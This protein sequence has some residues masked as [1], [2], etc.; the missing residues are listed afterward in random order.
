MRLLDLRCELK[1]ARNLPLLDAKARVSALL[2]AVLLAYGALASQPFSP[3]QVRHERPL[4]SASS[5]ATVIQVTPPSTQPSPLAREP[6]PPLSSPRAQLASLPI[7]ASFDFFSAYLTNQTYPDIVEGTP[8]DFGSTNISQLRQP[9]GGISYWDYWVENER[10]D[11][12]NHLWRDDDGHWHTYRSETIRDAA[13]K[14]VTAYVLFDV[15]GPGVMD[16]LWFTHDP[17][18]SF[19]AVLGE[20]NPLSFLEPQ[21][22]TQW[23][24]LAKLGNLRIQVDDQIVFDGP[25]KDWFSGQAQH[26][27]PLLR[28]IAVWKYI[29]FGSD[30][31][32][33]PI[34]YQNRLKVSVYGGSG[35]PKWFMAT[36]MK[37]PS[38]TLVRPY[39]S[40]DDLP[41]PQMEQLAE[42]VLNPDQ[43]F[44]TLIGKRDYQVTV[45]S[46]SP[47][48]FELKGSGSV[49]ALQFEIDKQYDPRKLQLLVRYGG[50]PGIIAPFLAFFGEADQVAPH[51]SSPIGYVDKGNTY[52]FYS[53]LPMPYQ[54]GMTIQL[55]TE[56]DT[57][58]PLI[59]RIAVTDMTFNTQ[60]RV[61]HDPGQK[62]MLY[63]PDYVVHLPGD[64]KVVGLV[65][66]TKDQGFDK[67]PLGDA[68]RKPW[69]MGYL[70]G[71]LTMVDGRG[72][73]RYY[74]G[75]E[76]WAEGGYYFNSGFTR[77]SGGGNRPF[78]GIL[79]YKPDKDGC[80]TLFRYFYDLSA[81]RFRNGL[82]LSFQHGTW[83][84][85][86]P[87]TYG[88]TI[89]YYSE[90][91]GMPSSK[92]PASE[93]LVSEA[94]QIQRTMKP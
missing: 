52:L 39:R 53:N 22:Q 46:H 74:S 93:Y 66:V 31:N 45:A 10:W 23:G 33:I 38:G 16:K 32:I 30:G 85:N 78:A 65:L 47:A 56:Q 69:P 64:G 41:L 28:Q 55:A 24:D 18:Q 49:E 71:N 29:D 12:P 8:W 27:G 87:V 48:T 50:K 9:N 14:N 19:M 40:P 76:D 89:F 54:S 3:I 1:E 6:N 84:N 81:F 72:A 73:T 61:Y 26:L 83:N 79:S 36:G 59:A 11:S 21:E 57:P 43:F 15:K 92:L 77:P 67:I 37:L 62:L 80:A 90:M 94:D 4:S 42:N 34:P 91:P 88:A 35:K 63:G 25:I 75:Q 86:F 58:I 2:C 5:E 44:D 70:E 13:G 7:Y 17:S 68:I 51:R 60:L 82:H 20:N